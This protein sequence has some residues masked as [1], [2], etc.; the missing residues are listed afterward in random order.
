MEMFQKDLLVVKIYDSRAEMGLEAAKEAAAVIRSL[1][2]EKEYVRIIFAAA[3]SQNE[4]LAGLAADQS[5]DFSRIDAFHMDEYIGLP[6]EAP[7]GFG[8]FLKAHIFDL[9]EFHSVTY[10]NG[11]NPD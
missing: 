5:I 10:L 7:Q 6:K 11:Q 9:R 2:R 4:F 1:Q 8:N 3:P